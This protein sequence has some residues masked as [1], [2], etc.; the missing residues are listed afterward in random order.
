MY[1]TFKRRFDFIKSNKILKKKKNILG[2]G[3]DMNVSMETK[4]IFRVEYVVHTVWNVGV[5]FLNNKIF[6]WEICYSQTEEG[7]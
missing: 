7:S 1:R 4:C 3:N 6:V 5:F 2:K